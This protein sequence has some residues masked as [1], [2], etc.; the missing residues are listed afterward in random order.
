MNAT[1]SPASDPDFTQGIPLD[2]LADGQMLAGHVG[3]DAV[4]LAR[5]GTDYFAIGATCSHYGGPLAEGLVVGDTVRCP[6][7][8]ACFSLR[9]GEAL[10][11]PAFNPVPCWRTEVSDGKV[12]VRDKVEHAAPRTATAARSRTGKPDRVVIVGGGG[13]GFAAAEMLRRDGFAGSLTLLSADD[14]APY[15][16]PNCSKDYLAGSAQEEWMPQRPPEFYQEQSIELQLRTEVTGIDAKARQITLADGR[17]LPFDR[18]LLA[19]GAEPILLDVPGADRPHVH[20]P[21]SLGD[22]QAIIANAQAARHAVVIGSSFI[23]LEAAAA[24]RTRG[25]EIHVVAPEQAPLE[26]V[27]GPEVGAFIRALHESGASFSISRTRWRRLA[28]ARPAQERTNAAGGACGGRHRCAARGRRSPNAPG[29]KVERGVIVNEY[30]ETSAPG[31]SPPATSRAGRIIARA[32]RLDRA[33]GCRRASR[34]GR[35]TEYPGRERAVFRC[36]VLLEPALRRTDQLCRPRREMGQG[37]D[38][39]RLMARDCLVRYRTVTA[40]CWRLRRSTG[41]S[42]T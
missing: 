41:I 5:C 1:Q 42:K 4:V 35:G 6:W 2:Q 38:R 34:P 9:T 20:P 28:R 24:L 40:R 25:L 31:S 27:L 22:L 30:L 10:E 26:R 18:L 19:T 39:W 15:D 7:H 16:R 11:A 33:L 12:M 36:A 32:T 23:G 17:S 14:A 21:R 3:D 29:L 13:A 37:R 8:H